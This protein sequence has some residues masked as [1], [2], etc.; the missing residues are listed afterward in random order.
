MASLLGAALYRIKEASWVFSQVCGGPKIQTQKYQGHNFFTIILPPHCQRIV[1]TPQ[2]IYL[3]TLWSVS[4]PALVLDLSTFNLWHKSY[5]YSSRIQSGP[6]LVLPFKAQVVLSNTLPRH[7]IALYVNIILSTTLFWIGF[8]HLFFLINKIS[9]VGHS[10]IMHS[11][12]S[13]LRCIWGFV[14]LVSCVISMSWTSGLIK[15]IK[16]CCLCSAISPTSIST[17]SSF[18]VIS[19]CKYCSKYLHRTI[20]FLINHR[21]ENLLHKQNP[22]KAINC[23]KPPIIINW[24]AQS[25]SRRRRVIFLFKI[26]AQICAALKVTGGG[27]LYLLFVI[28]LFKIITA[29]ICAALKVTREV[30]SNIQIF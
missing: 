29:Q 8:Y 16:R 9:T 28:F 30:G 2:V 22:P 17:P 25:T 11:V 6:A 13:Y 12:L 19:L 27:G 10:N 21:W 15:I 1:R 18:K 20:I 14:S 26:T 23:T 4:A 3:S 7:Q 5:Q 24:Q